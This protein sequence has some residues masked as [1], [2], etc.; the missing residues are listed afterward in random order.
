MAIVNPQLPPKA[1]YVE[2]EIDGQRQYQRVMNEQD[3]QIAAL[4]QANVELA[5][6]NT[7]L[8]D[9]L[10]TLMIDILPALMV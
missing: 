1:G 5:E 8:S 7:L 6:K 3:A 9:T 2:V 10:D 4:Q